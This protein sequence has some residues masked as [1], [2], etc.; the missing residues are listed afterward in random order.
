MLFFPRTKYFHY[1]F[2]QFLFHSFCGACGLAALLVS[3]LAAYALG[4][5]KE[6]IQDGLHT[7]SVVLFG[8]GFATNFEWG[9]AFALLLV[10]GALLTLFYQQH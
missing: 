10:I 6:Q 8:L 2:C 7:Y 9:T 3:L 4:F 5:G 1:S